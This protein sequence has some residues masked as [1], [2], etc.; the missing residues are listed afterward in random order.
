MADNKYRM[1]PPLMSDGRHI[2]NYVNNAVTDEYIRKSNNIIDHNHYRTFL[3]NNGE[4]II[5][6]NKKRMETQFNCDVSIQCSLNNSC[7]NYS[8]KAKQQ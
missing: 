4:L 8:I 6:N 1:C 5:N 7:N 3:Q 2:T